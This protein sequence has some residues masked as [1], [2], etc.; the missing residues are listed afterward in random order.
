MTPPSLRR[1]EARRTVSI[2]ACALLTGVASAAQAQQ[3]SAA[4]PPEVTD[5][6]AKRASILLKNDDPLPA[7][8]PLA[9]ALPENIVVVCEAGCP[10]GAAEVVYTARREPS[11]APA[12]PNAAAVTA[13]TAQC[14]AGCYARQARKD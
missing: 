8:H 4:A 10:T 9:A 7:P 12:A 5:Y 14:I 13:L 6:Y 1:R 11:G 3:Q 2:L